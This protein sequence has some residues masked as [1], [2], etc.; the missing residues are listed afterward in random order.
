MLSQACGL[1]DAS[2][3]LHFL[4]SQGRTVDG[5]E[6][7]IATIVPTLTMMDDEIT[8]LGNLLG[9]QWSQE[10]V[11]ELFE[12][13]GAGVNTTFCVKQFVKG[14]Y[15]PTAYNTLVQTI[16]QKAPEIAGRGKS[17]L[18][19]FLTSPEMSL[20]TGTVQLR[21]SD[22]TNLITEAGGYAALVVSDLRIL[23]G[24]GKRYTAFNQLGNAIK[25]DMDLKDFKKKMLT[26]L[27]S[28]RHKL[29]RDCLS[30][31]M[32]EESANSLLAEGAGGLDMPEILHFVASSPSAPYETLKDVAEHCRGFA[33]ERN[34]KIAEEIQT[35]FN[36]LGQVGNKLFKR[37]I[38]VN[39]GTIKKLVLVIF[40]AHHPLTGGDCVP[41]LKKIVERG[42]SFCS[43][44]EL[45]EKVIEIADEEEVFPPPD[46]PP[47]AETLSWVPSFNFGPPPT[48]D[49]D[50]I[51]P[52]PDDMGPPPD[53]DYMPPPS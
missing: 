30:V 22:V 8:R 17:E 24:L 10:K 39:N 3:C 35:T 47:P 25:T 18:I 44:E 46:D 19:A 20:F 2:Q 12:A 51:G 13:G 32:T 53:D 4:A 5:F 45:E 14:P 29:F 42:L 7:L 50:D 21:Q 38:D 37:E 28:L 40:N 23:D 26:V 48:M 31:P 34:N 41:P 43:M 6:S 16:K 1:H 52:P 33:D 49:D 11:V 15:L 36:Y 9:A 27:F